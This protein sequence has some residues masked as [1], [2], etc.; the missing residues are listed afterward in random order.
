MVVMEKSALWPMEQSSG[1]PV[2]R[3]SF[4]QFASDCETARKFY[5]FGRWV[6]PQL[7]HF[8]KYLFFIECFDELLARS[9]K[10]SCKTVFVCQSYLLYLSL[11][12]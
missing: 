12:S 6:G 10:T 2:T 1:C 11:I 4:F 7:Y 3:Y 9:Q 8:E 5:I